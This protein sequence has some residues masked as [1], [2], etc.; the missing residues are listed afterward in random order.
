VLPAVPRRTLKA[1]FEWMLNQ[2]QGKVGRRLAG[3]QSASTLGTYWKVFRLVY[4]RAA[5]EKIEGKMNRHMHRV[6]SIACLPAQSTSNHR[7]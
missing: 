6:S 3:I 1:F 7:R 5:G 4:E 2:R